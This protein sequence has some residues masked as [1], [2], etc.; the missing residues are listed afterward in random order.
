MIV[1]VGGGGLVSGDP[2]P[3]SAPPVD[4]R[5]RGRARDE[6][7]AARRASPPARPIAGRAALDRRRSERSLRR[8]GSPIEICRELERVLVTEEEIEDAFRFLYERTKLACEPAAA[9]ACRRPARGQGRGRANPVAIV[10]G[11]NVA[12]QTASAI[13]AVAMK[14][15]IHPSTCSRPSTA[16]AGT[17]SS[18]ARPS[19]S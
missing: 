8:R 6:P 19:P 10:S 11:G 7:G 2:S 15:E 9:A 1:P 12:S 16:P 4:A 13:L 18:P 3:R 17:R 14:A 5:D